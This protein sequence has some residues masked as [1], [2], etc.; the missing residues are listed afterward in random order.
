M[1][2]P[3]IVIPSSSSHSSFDHS[4]DS[5]SVAGSPSFQKPS[6]STTRHHH[7]SRKRKLGR[8]VGS[9]N[10]PKPLLLIDRANKNVV[11]PVFI[12]VPDT[13]DVIRTI[14]EFARHHHVSI[15][16]LNAS[17]TVSNV[18]IRNT[19]YHASPFTL[20]GPFKLISLTGTYLHNA[21][22]HGSS[23]LS[24]ILNND[25]RCSFG[26]SV[27]GIKEQCFIGGVGGKVVAENGVMVAAVIVNKF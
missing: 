21:A 26:V 16:V 3:A 24:S 25:P 2:E 14:V 8:P 15:V 6:S 11:K 22:F 20:Y 17:G 13:Y 1:V 23:S 4:T 10:K 19:H 9:K 18:T 27:S 7:L 12:E 5:D